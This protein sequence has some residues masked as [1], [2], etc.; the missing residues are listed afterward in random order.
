MTESTEVDSKTS[1]LAMKI[2]HFLSNK[3]VK[4]LVPLV[5]IVLLGV[6]LYQQLLMLTRLPEFL[7]LF[8]IIDILV[9][10][11]LSLPFLEKYLQ[12]VLK[13]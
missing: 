6:I 5:T 10:V 4:I 3:R 8:I 1:R 11:G 2:E 7:F 13:R 9:L 12:R